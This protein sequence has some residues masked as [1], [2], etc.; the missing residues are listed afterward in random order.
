MKL[1]CKHKT[2]QEKIFRE[3]VDI[4]ISFALKNERPN[5]ISWQKTRLFVRR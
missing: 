2:V 3:N 1:D 5:T 4:L